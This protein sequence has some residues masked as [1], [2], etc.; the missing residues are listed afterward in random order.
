MI[1][2]IEKVTEKYGY[3]HLCSLFFLF[4]FKCFHLSICY[5]SRF[6]F[7]SLSLFQFCLFVVC[8]FSCTFFFSVFP[9]DLWNVSAP[10][11]CTLWTTTS[12]TQTR[13]NEGIIKREHTHIIRMLKMKAIS[14]SRAVTDDFPTWISFSFPIFF[15]SF[16]FPLSLPVPCKS[17]VLEDDVKAHCVP[18][19]QTCKSI[20]SLSVM[21]SPKKNPSEYIQSHSHSCWP[22]RPASLFILFFFSS[23]MENQ[24][25]LILF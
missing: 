22:H 11:L 3:N 25:D 7:H 2:C 9:F 14:P 23:R 13:L 6:F 20:K 1:I 4:L 17:L 19:W 24:R 21:H 15:F 10:Y 5:W 16:I 12:T 18:N 8:Y